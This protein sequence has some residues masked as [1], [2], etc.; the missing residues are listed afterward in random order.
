MRS[1]AAAGNTIVTTSRDQTMRIWDADRWR[2]KET[3]AVQKAWQAAWLASIV[4]SHDRRRLISGS[5]SAVGIWDAND[6]REIARLQGHDADVLAVAVSADGRRI[7]S[8]S[9][10]GSVR[11]WDMEAGQEIACGLGH[12][13][14][15]SSVALTPDGMHAL[16]GGE[17]RTVRVCACREGTSQAGHIRRW[18]AQN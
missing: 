15:V 6:G 7:V 12:Q 17:D 16:S 14:E 5:G 8:G 11:V 1:I 9:V 3:L 10:D 2:L 13:G 4:V 18:R